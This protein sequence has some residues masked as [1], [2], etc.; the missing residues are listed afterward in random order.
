MDR[1]PPAM[2]KVRLSVELLEQLGV[3]HS[4]DEIVG[5]VAVRDHRKDGGFPLPDFPQLHFICLANACQ[6]GQ[7]E[8]FQVGD[9][10]DLDGF[11]SFAAAGVVALVVP[12]GNMLRVLPFQ[13]LEQLVQGGN[14]FLVV[15]LHITGPDHFHDHGEILFLRGCFIVEVGN[16]GL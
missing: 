5:A 11:Q 13:P 1:Q 7:V 16:Q 10:G 8:L 15:L 3:E 6:R 2:L 12:H 9:Q 4:D 14:V